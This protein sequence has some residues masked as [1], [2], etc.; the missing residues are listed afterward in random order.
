MGDFLKLHLWKALRD[1]AGADID[2]VLLAL[3]LV[4]TVIVLDAVTAILSKKR[5]ESGIEKA[6]PA[7]SVDGSKTI[8]GKSY[9]SDIQG[10][11][12]KPDALIVEDGYFIPIERKPLARKIRDR[13][14]AQLLVYMRLVEEFEGKKPPYGY[15][16]LGPNVRKVKV[17]NSAERQA[18]L[19][20]MLD[21]MRAILEKKAVPIAAPHLIKCRKCDVR[22]SC[23]FRAD[24]SG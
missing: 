14:V 1:V 9:V 3:L 19:Q 15:L 10:L 12:G 23:Q 21:E 5:K 13:Y 18:W 22:D 17:E 4:C 11:A 6:A 20:H 7:V 2:L 16:L 24:S 8:P